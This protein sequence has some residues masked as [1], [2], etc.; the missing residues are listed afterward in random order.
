MIAISTARYRVLWCEIESR[1]AERVEQ[2][3]GL[4]KVNN[5]RAL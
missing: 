5:A 4:I 2:K 1:E 3:L